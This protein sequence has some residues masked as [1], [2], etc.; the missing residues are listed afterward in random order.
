MGVSHVTVQAVRAVA[1]SGGQLDHQSERVGKDGVKQPAR[2][3]VRTAS[4]PT[5]TRAMSTVTNETVAQPNVEQLTTANVAEFPHLKHPNSKRGEFPQFNRPKGHNQEVIPMY[6][7]RSPAD[8]LAAQIGDT[9]KLVEF[10]ENMPPCE[11]RDR[12]L[13][14][15]DALL[16]LQKQAICLLNP[17]SK[18][19]TA[20]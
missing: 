14:R 6:D 1:E 16:W 8:V 2:K 20:H 9:R 11:E 5:V 4:A 3:P 13:A 18:G 10:A 12:I 17:S 15:V 19:W 7:D